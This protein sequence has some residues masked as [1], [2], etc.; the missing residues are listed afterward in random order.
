MVVRNFKEEQKQRDKR[1]QEIADQLKTSSTDPRLDLARRAG[2]PLEAFVPNKTEQ[3]A[4]ISNQEQTKNVFEQQAIKEAAQ[5][6]QNI[7][8]QSTPSPVNAPLTPEEQSIKKG[9][10]QFTQNLGQTI[11]LI[12]NPL[13]F[14]SKISAER[15]ASGSP[16]SKLSPFN[17][18]INERVQRG[19]AAAHLLSLRAISALSKVTGVTG[20]I[21]KTLASAEATRSDNINAMNSLAVLVENGDLTLS[22]ARARFV[23]YQQQIRNAERVV[24]AITQSDT[25]K[26]ISGGNDNMLKFQNAVQF[27]IPDAWK[28]ILEADLISRQ[29]NIGKNG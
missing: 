21:T 16:D 15:L 5:T 22:Q 11:D 10:E 19:S 18:A 8:L 4:I 9:Q 6:Q 17:S 7:E 20:D 29:V 3:R 2:V 1:N 14:A 12:S 23:T 26:F 28:D 27:E 25:G 24:K 13:K